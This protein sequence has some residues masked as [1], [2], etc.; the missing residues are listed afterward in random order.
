MCPETHAKDEIRL[1]KA[2][3]FPK[4]WEFYTN[5]D[6]EEIQDDIV[7]SRKRTH[8]VSSK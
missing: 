5:S 4:K 1:Y 2:I 3:D 8:L 7:I 6:I